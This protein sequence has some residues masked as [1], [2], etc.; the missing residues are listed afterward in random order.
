MASIVSGS[1]ALALEHDVLSCYKHLLGDM[2]DIERAKGKVW[3]TNTS[4][5]TRDLI[6]GHDRPVYLGHTCIIQAAVLW[7]ECRVVYAYDPAL[8]DVLVGQD[9]PEVPCE[10]LRHLPQW[11]TCITGFDPTGQYIALYAYIDG[12]ELVLL[13]QT[14]RGKY[15]DD[16]LTL[17]PGED[18]RHA[19]RANNR[20]TMALWGSRHLLGYGGGEYNYG[21]RTGVPD[22][23][24]FIPRR[25]EVE[26]AVR[27]INLLLYLCADNAET[28]CV[29][30]RPP[31]VSTPDKPADVPLPVKMTS[32]Q[33]GI[34]IGAAIR[35][36]VQAE[37]DAAGSAPGHHASPA[38]HVR[39]AH[40][41]TYWTG[42]GRKIP[43]V[44]WIQPVLVG[45]RQADQT[46]S[47]VVRPV[48]PDAPGDK[49]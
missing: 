10:A 45:V 36:A 14:R 18:V 16:I 23:P 29:T 40:Y 20:K 31:R 39:R 22:D 25:V 47:T 21:A 13:W 44:R 7:R 17:T 35:K 33:V 5:I 24:E 34:R 26:R 2:A 15:H 41:A 4:W 30:S 1:P 42:P 46:I 11:C 38:P 49:E 8:A 37:A 27:G 9:M 12:D 6:H 19:I 48:M 32:Y 3:L 28:H 43:V